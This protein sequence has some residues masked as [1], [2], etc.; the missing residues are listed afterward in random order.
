MNLEKAIV[1][2]VLKIL[3]LNGVRRFKKI[4]TF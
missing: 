1:N 3:G 4:L 2:F